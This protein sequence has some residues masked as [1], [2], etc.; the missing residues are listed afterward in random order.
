MD[1][2]AG[3]KEW[4]ELLLPLLIFGGLYLWRNLRQFTQSKRLK[5]I[6]PFLNSE[7]VARPFTAPRLRGSY[8]GTPF[9]MR[10][11]PAS[12]SGPGR[13]QLRLDFGCGFA[14]DMIPRGRTPGLESLFAKGKPLETGDEAFDS[15]VIARADKERD[16]A[17][18][19]LDNPENRAA[20]TR[21][22]DDGF[23]SIR[24]TTEGVTLSKPGEFLEGE[25]LTS[26]AALH[27]LDLSVRLL[28][29]L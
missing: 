3:W 8:M 6:A 9:E 26:E 11:L 23:D 17:A 28:Q 20:V 13:M 22:F 18:L 10:F 14:L 24:F 25:G 19:F 2:L 12:K 21:L 29:R 1:L 7:V 5:E 4:I 27:D 16:R 15:A